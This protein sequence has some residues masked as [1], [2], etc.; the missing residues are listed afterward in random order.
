MTAH[1]IPTRRAALG[2]GVGLILG[3]TTLLGAC[4]TNGSSGSLE[5]SSADA[6]TTTAAAAKQIRGDRYCEVLLITMNAGS[7]TGEVWNTYPLNDCPQATWDTLDAKA[8]A[9]ENNVPIAKLNGPRYWLMSSVEKVGGVAELP[10]KDFGGLEM[11]RQATVEIGSLLEAA[12]PYLPHSVNRT[13][14]F[15]YDAGARVYELHTPEGA[16]YVMQTYSVQIDPTLTEAQLTDLGTRLKLP[17]GWTYT[18]QIL[19]APLKVQ[20]A[21]TAAHVLQDELGN[22]YSE[23]VTN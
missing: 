10:K 14:A 5:D 11:Y 6:S 9:T 16:N 19:D 18:S 13:A 3:V 8:I 15:T 1:R 17:E 4:G 20:T 21:T 23:L 22:S 7:A 12:K 2:L